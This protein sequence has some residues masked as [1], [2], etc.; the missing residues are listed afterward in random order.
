ML[1]SWDFQWKINFY[2]K[3]ILREIG[4]NVVQFRKKILY[5]FIHGLYV[6]KKMDVLLKQGEDLTREWNTN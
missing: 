2:F 6:E 5:I 4:T 3:K 1:K